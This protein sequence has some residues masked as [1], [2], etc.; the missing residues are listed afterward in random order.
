MERI[1]V[2]MASW[3]HHPSVWDE[4]HLIGGVVATIVV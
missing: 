4:Q 3:G 2:A 1:R